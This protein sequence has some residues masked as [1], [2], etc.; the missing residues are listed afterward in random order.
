MKYDDVVK[1]WL[2]ARDKRTPK[3][4][5]KIVSRD[6]YPAYFLNPE[7]IQTFFNSEEDPYSLYVN[8]D[9]TTLMPH[10]YETPAINANAAVLFS[11]RNDLKRGFKDIRDMDNE[12]SDIPKALPI[13]LAAPSI[14]PDP[15]AWA[16]GIIPFI[17]FPYLLSKRFS[18]IIFCSWIGWVS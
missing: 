16:R 8:P 3:G 17:K 10:D 14:I 4:I 1:V 6:N 9:T 7:D 11:T 5:S 15:A 2:E 12:Y 18:K 13:F